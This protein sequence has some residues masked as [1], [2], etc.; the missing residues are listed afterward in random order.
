MFTG[1][2]LPDPD[3]YSEYGSESRRGSE[4]FSLK[5]WYSEPQDPDQDPK[6]F[7]KGTLLQTIQRTSVTLILGL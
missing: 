7:G 4:I 3:P 1:I 5:M 2:D 6:R